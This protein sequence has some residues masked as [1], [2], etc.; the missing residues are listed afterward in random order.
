MLDNFNFDHLWLSDQF[1]D[2]KGE[3]K[4]ELQDYRDAALAGD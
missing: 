4:E 2:R 3:E 1:S